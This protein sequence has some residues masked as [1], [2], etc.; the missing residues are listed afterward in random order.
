MK[1]ILILGANNSQVQLIQ[2][3]KKEGYYVVVC[4]YAD[5]NP[6]LPLVDK[7]YQ[8]SYLDQEEVLS[9]A[10]EEH[11]DGVIGNQT[12]AACNRVPT[13][14]VLEKFIDYRLEFLH[15]L[16][17]WKHFGNGWGRRVQILKETCERYL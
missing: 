9:I 7:H 13:R 3:A 12:I 1:K 15:G 14:Q 6:G 8:V 2:A 10:K 4:D 17:D 16:K 5:D 11:I